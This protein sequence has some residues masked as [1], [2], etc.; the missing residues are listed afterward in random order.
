MEEYKEILNELREIAPALARLKKTNFFKAPEGYFTDFNAQ[1]LEKIGVTELKTVAPALSKI[2]KIATATVPAAYFNTLP[3]ELI[4]KIRA[5]EVK[6]ELAEIAPALSQLEK[7]GVFAAPAGYFS[8]LPEQLLKKVQPKS[9]SRSAVA[10]GFISSLDTLLNRLGAAL[11]KPKYTVAF[12][13]VATSL[14]IAGMLFFHVQQGNDLDCRFAQLSNDEI[15]NYLS[16][17]PDPDVSTGEIF[18]PVD[19]NSY[20]DID[21]KNLHPYIDALKD[22]DDATLNEAIKD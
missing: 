8:S 3:N 9:A 20:P 22:V 1:L 12:A 19:E 17:H 13:G 4:N 11:F 16:T 7:A 10:P 2:H 5:A 21:T 6:G 14:I 15:N 18:A